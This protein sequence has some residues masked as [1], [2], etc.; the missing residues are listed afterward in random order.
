MRI[1]KVEIK[2]D[3]C[4]RLMGDGGP[5][6][7]LSFQMVDGGG[8]VLAHGELND[9]CE[10]CQ[11]RLLALADMIVLSSPPRKGKKKNAKGKDK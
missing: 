3:R 4:G 8:T 11:K 5:V 10:R 2:C 1:E 7:K 9:I 6:M